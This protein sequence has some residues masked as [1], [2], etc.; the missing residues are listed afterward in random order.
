MGKS[1]EC[2]LWLCAVTPEIN[3]NLELY[4]QEASSESLLDQRIRVLSIISAGDA[5]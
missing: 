4:T 2:H 5:T 1:C 3:S